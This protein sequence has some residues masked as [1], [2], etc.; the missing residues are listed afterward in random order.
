MISNVLDV[1]LTRADIVLTTGGLEDEVVGLTHQAIAEVT[2]QM[3]LTAGESGAVTL[4][5]SGKQ[6][7][8]L[9]VQSDNGTL[10]CLPGNRREMAYLLETEVLP[11]IQERLYS[12][13]KTGWA[14][15]R[16]IDIMESTLKQKLSDL[17]VASQH[18]ITYDSYA[19]Q[20]NVQLWIEADSEEEI[21]RKLGHLKQQ[22]YARLGD[23]IFGEG[24][25]R[26][27]DVVSL[28]LEKSGRKLAVVEL[29][30]DKS[31]VKALNGSPDSHEMVLSLP[32]TTCD[33]L[34]TF[35]AIE[36]P[37][38]EHDAKIW[39]QTAA[40]GL[41]I[42]TQADLGLVLYE[43][44]TQGGIQLFVALASPNGV[45]VTERSFGG[46]P[47]NINQWACTLGLAH[48]RRWLLTYQ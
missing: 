19:G 15:L 40:E 45:S 37:R 26:L 36:K 28:A 29:F 9:L 14:L 44:I 34:A 4:G 42:K 35:L 21:E 30:T 22:V 1:A 25:N 12:E 6:P 31:L 38:G 41:L 48:L 32:M 18:R 2:G 27:E 47:E 46:H 33:E 3:P 8:G 43:K 13:R 39:S 5:G 24:E 17:A 7:S 10:I 11:L 20:T 23:H 16:T